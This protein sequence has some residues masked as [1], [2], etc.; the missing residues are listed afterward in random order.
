MVVVFQMNN[1]PKIKKGIYV[2]L[3]LSLLLG[4]DSVRIFGPESTLV[5]DEKFLDYKE[6]II[7]RISDGGKNVEQELRIFPDGRTILTSNQRN[8]ETNIELSNSQINDLKNTFETNNFE[9]L[10][11]AYFGSEALDFNQY[12]VFYQSEQTGKTVVTD[13]F[14]VPQNLQN[15]I[16]KI[17]SVINSI[18]YNGLEFYLSVNKTVVKENESID[19][20]FTVE[21][22]TNKNIQLEFPSKQMYDI[23]ASFSPS[24]NPENIVWKWS[25]NKMFAQVVNYSILEAGKSRTF[26]VTWDCRDDSGV[27]LEG[28]FYLTGELVSMPGGKS[29][30]VQASIE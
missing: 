27:R 1:S 6:I 4:C 15:I 17:N 9:K 26:T 7:V 22:A 11:S 28:T 24:Q 25:A 16:N 12:Q 21:N 20:S 3:T 18:L 5:A 14:D 30:A 13:L 10:D 29:E 23:T 8:A 19:L 2:L